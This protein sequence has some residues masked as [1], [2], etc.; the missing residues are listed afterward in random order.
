MTHTVDLTIRPG[1]F[2]EVDEIT[3]KDLKRQGLINS[4]YA[5]L[6][7]VPT[8]K[9]TPRSRKGSATKKEVDSK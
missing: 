8:P 1:W 4:E 2:I 6:K 5:E 3:F 7:E 9:E